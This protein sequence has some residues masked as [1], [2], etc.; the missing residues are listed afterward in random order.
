MGACLNRVS[1]VSFSPRSD[2]YQPRRDPASG[3]DRG[4]YRSDRSPDASRINTDKFDRPRA[5]SADR[6]NRSSFGDRR[7]DD[8][9]STKQWRERPPSDR[10]NRGGWQDRPDPEVT[11]EEVTDY[12]Y[13]KHSVFTAIENER[14]INRIW[15]LSLNSATIQPFSP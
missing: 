4:G 11:E 12:L 6:D 10:Q 13:G 9:S 2:K 8:R 5:T 14:Q 3:E 1:L 7:S 15:V